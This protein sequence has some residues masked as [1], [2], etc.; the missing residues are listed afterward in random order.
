M[1]GFNN[2]IIIESR[3]IVYRITLVC[4]LCFTYDSICLHVNNTSVTLQLFNNINRNT[5]LYTR[6]E[7]PEISAVFYLSF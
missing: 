7:I 2:E 3:T 4:E 1:F 6:C 5:S